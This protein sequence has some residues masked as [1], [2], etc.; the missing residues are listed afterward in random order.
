MEFWQT[1]LEH[2][3]EEKSMNDFALAIDKIQK[4]V[5]SNTLTNVAWNSAKLAEKDLEKTITEL[6]Q[7]SG[8]DIFVA[9][10]SNTNTR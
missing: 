9:L 1:V 4:I 3:S 10:L 8:K 5:F 7:Q 2:P 6:K